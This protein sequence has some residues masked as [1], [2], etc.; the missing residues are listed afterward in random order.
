MSPETLEKICGIFRKYHL[1]Q[2][3]ITQLHWIIAEVGQGKRVM[4]VAPHP[5]GQ[6]TVFKAAKEIIELLNLDLKKLVPRSS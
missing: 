5:A 6:T 2:R 1:T 3:Q 4:Y